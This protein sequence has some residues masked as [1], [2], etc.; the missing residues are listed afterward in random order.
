MLF[1]KP[2]SADRSRIAIIYLFTYLLTVFY[3]AFLPEGT[4][5][6]LQKNKC[7]KCKACNITVKKH[8]SDKELTIKTVLKWVQ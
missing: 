4:K 3:P 6:N 7:K 5:S 2:N 8:K 1:F